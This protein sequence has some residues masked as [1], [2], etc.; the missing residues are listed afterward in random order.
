MAQQ[1][2]RQGVKRTDWLGRVGQGAHRLSNQRVEYEVF[3]LCMAKGGGCPN[4][5]I[6]IIYPFPHFQAS[7]SV[8][9]ASAAKGGSS[10][11]SAA[12]Q[13]PAAPLSPEEFEALVVRLEGLM[14][15]AVSQESVGWQADGEGQMGLCPPCGRRGQG[16]EGIEALRGPLHWAFGPQ[17]AGKG[18]NIL[19]QHGWRIH[20]RNIILLLLF[21]GR[22]ILLAFASLFC[23]FPPPPCPQS[24][25][26]ACPAHC[27]RPSGFC[28]AVLPPLSSGTV[29]APGIRRRCWPCTTIG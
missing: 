4:I 26:I 25:R 6:L 28:P 1:A 8:S 22:I 11:A 23:L 29:A 21:I 13:P 9:G 5:Y 24:K 7:A 2:Q 20:P 14:Q 18:R 12:K 15:E 17:G 10:G 27:R 3:P 19:Q 16:C